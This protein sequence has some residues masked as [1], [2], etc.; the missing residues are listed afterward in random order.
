MLQPNAQLVEMLQ[1]IAWIL[2][3]TISAGAL[4]SILSVAAG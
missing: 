1:Q 3:D 4:E 2:I